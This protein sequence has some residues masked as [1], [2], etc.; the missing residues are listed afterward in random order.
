MASQR[1]GR[2]PCKKTDAA[3]SAH[4]KGTIPMKAN[5]SGSR[6]RVFDADGHQIGETYPKRARGLVKHG[7][8]VWLTESSYAQDPDAECP[9]LL[10]FPRDEAGETDIQSFITQREDTSMSEYNNEHEQRIHDMIA[11]FRT[12]MAKARE[13]A[14]K[15]AA[16]AEN[17]IR[18]MHDHARRCL[19]NGTHVLG[20]TSDAEG[21]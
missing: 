13:I 15:A 1:G 19:Y 17:V 14:E 18:G 20:Y 8:A 16:E 11:Q 9:D 5:G 6:I 12:E 4:R 2:H 3:S 21:H 10:I 7:R